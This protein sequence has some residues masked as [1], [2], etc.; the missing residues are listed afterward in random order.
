M[1]GIEP[2]QASIRH[3]RTEILCFIL[4]LVGDQYLSETFVS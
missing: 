2:L 4:K 1:Y 3:K